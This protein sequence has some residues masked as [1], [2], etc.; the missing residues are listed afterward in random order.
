MATGAPPTS[1]SPFPGF[2]FFFILV[3][4]SVSARPSYAVTELVGTVC[5]QTSNC[6]FCVD[7]LYTDPRTPEAKHFLSFFF[8]KIQS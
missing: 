8:G 7:V 6:T 4:I 5:K 1:R 2:L 3:V